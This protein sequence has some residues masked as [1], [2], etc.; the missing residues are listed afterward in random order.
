MTTEADLLKA[1]IER[2]NDASLGL[3]FADWLDERG[4]PRAEFFRRPIIDKAKTKAVPN[5]LAVL[6]SAITVQYEDAAWTRGVYGW[7]KFREGKCLGS[8]LSDHDVPLTLLAARAYSKWPR[9]TIF[10][11]LQ[12]V[13]IVRYGDKRPWW[14]LCYVCCG[15]LRTD[16]TREYL[17]QSDRMTEKEAE[18]RA[19]KDADWNGVPFVG[20][21]EAPPSAFPGWGRPMV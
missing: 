16:G 8:N 5:N 12:A 1:M 19:K 9:Y 4:D 14:S 13:G 18:A 20:L 10:T 6:Y 15:Y 21:V 3:I 2:P 7:Q 11:G 17:P